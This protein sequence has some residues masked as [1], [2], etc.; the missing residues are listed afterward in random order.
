MGSCIVAFSGGVDS[1]Y[2]ALI[3]HQEL[4]LRPWPSPLR[5][6]AIPR[7]SETSLWIS[8]NDM[9]FATNSSLPARWKTRTTPR[10]L[11]PLLLLQA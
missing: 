9:V 3:A 6:P 4:G 11:E 10:I 7:I 5:A 1:A 8:S 2:L